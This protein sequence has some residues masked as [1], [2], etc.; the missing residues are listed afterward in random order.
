MFLNSISDYKEG[1]RTAVEIEL[2]EGYLARDRSSIRSTLFTYS[3]D[4]GPLPSSQPETLV[5]RFLAFD[6]LKNIQILL[7]SNSISY[8]MLG[9]SRIDPMQQ[10]KKKIYVAD[11]DPEILSALSAMLEDAGY[12]VRASPCGKPVFEGTYSS[13]DLFILDCQMPDID[14]IELCRYLRAQSATRG[15]PVILISAKPRSGSEALDA[16]ANDYIEKPFHMPYL[17]Y[18]V[19]KYARKGIV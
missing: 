4:N 6:W 10:L 12:K 16:G 11:D 1:S 18:V 9:E 7:D 3:L 8:S 2:W 5:F 15:T 13:V 14:G 17:L 19:S